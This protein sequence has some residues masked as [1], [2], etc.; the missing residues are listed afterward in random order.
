MREGRANRSILGRAGAIVFALLPWAA[1]CTNDVDAPADRIVIVSGNNQAGLPGDVL[2]EPLVVHVVGPRSRDFLGRRGERPPAPGVEVTFVV[3]GLAKRMDGWRA[4]AGA[5]ELA[6]H[7]SLYEDSSCVG[8]PEGELRVLS[9]EDGLARVWTKLGRENG[10]WRI[11]AV[12]RPTPAAK[13]VKEH[14]RLVVGVRKVEEIRE[15]SIGD[16]VPLRLE[17]R[18][19]AGPGAE[20]RPLADREVWYRIVGEPHGTSESAEISNKRDSTTREGIRQG[21]SVT[22]GDRPGI[23]HVLAEVEPKRRAEGED[24]D[25]TTGSRSDLPI[26]GILFRIVAHDVVSTVTQLAIGLVFFLVGVR[27]LASGLLLLTSHYLHFESGP[28]TERRV[29]GYLGGSV[30]GATFQSWS[31]VASHLVSFANGGI[32]S[33][34]GGFM[35]LAGASLGATMLPQVL[36]LHLGFLA[37]PSLA[38]GW[39]LLL[40]PRRRGLEAWGWVLLGA[41]LVLIAFS[42]LEEGVKLLG[43]SERLR[44]EL[45]LLDINA[46]LGFFARLRDYS[47]AA[48]LGLA[49]GFVLRTSNLVVVVAIAAASERLLVVDTGIALI[50]GANLGSALR[51]LVRSSWKRREARR[52]AT[53]GMLFHVATFFLVT[54]LS[55]VRVGGRSALLWLV[56]GSA[57]GVLL[58]PTSED[59]AL[60]LAMAHTLYNAL[61]GV[62]VLAWPGP[63]LAI[64]D[65]LLP[66][67]AVTQELKPQHLDDQLIPVPSLALRQVG[68]EVVYLTELSQKTV[69]EAFDAFRYA[70][71]G[72]ADQ[73]VRRGE[74][75]VGLQRDIVRYLALVDENPLARRDARTMYIL[76]GAAT[77]LVRVSEC[78]ERLHDLTIRRVEEKLESSEETD[79]ELGEVYDLVIGQFENVISLLE[80]RDSRRQENVV[81]T[82]ERLA[83]LRSRLETQWRA[84]VE[85]NAKEGLS[86][87]KVHLQTLVYQEAFDLLFRV[88]SNLADISQRLRIF[89]GADD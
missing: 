30:I 31:T 5:S 42:S 70:D 18:E 6:P 76:Q 83:K 64:V 45:R 17:L 68:R 41:G 79:R 3:E 50:I 7:P 35:L 77:S 61:G 72:L 21:S 10:D 74:T 33:A 85:K 43:L 11:E 60:H 63:L 39:L 47:A 44:A 69:A 1:G 36:S 78:A 75:V 20:L 80:T 22:L 88:A 26:R 34:R 16:E 24:A 59:V 48:A 54:I 38:A 56:D 65:R 86:A 14:F 82:L 51:L 55:M 62:I 89:A 66:P 52:L 4:D 73:V 27:F 46:K 67:R 81:K 84:R 13:P 49:A 32:L 23:Y 25:G 40:L 57:P 53:L 28:W 29:L 87:V 12:I 71:P 37:L 15:A 19:W 58:H 8:P 2:P 9:D